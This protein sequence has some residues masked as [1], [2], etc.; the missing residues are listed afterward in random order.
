MA[1][2][3]N[4]IKI[5]KLLNFGSSSEQEDRCVYT[6]DPAYDETKITAIICG[7]CG[8][9]HTQGNLFLASTG[10]KRLG[11][12]NLPIFKNGQRI[13]TL[14]S[15]QSMNY[16]KKDKC[17]PACNQEWENAHVTKVMRV[18]FIALI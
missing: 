8:F 4:L 18:V 12:T 16:F 2:F 17:C 6:T 13:Q 3:W 11:P 10:G 1:N 7:H 14:K 9:H 5:K 15:Y